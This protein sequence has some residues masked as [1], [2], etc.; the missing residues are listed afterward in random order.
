MKD[1]K[2]GGAFIWSLDL[3]DFDGHF[4]GQGKNPLIG[5]LRSLLNSGE[6]YLTQTSP[7]LLEMCIPVFIVI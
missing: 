4:C 3:D 6:P 2:F 5:Y 1:G 7:S